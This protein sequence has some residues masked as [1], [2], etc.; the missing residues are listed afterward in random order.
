VLT[1]TGVSATDEADY[2]VTVSNP[3]GSI[4]SDV[5]HLTVL[6]APADGYLAAVL[7]DGPISLWRLEESA[8]PMAYDSLNGRDGNY[9]GGV[10]Y[11]QPGFTSGDLSVNFPNSGWETEPPSTYV[12]VPY[13]ATLNPSGAFS[14]E[15]WTKISSVPNDLFSPLAA[16]DMNAG[17]S[18]YLFYLNGGSGWQFRMGNAAGAYVATVAGGTTTTDWQHIVGV[19]DGAGNASLYVN[20]IQY[21]PVALSGA[22]NPNATQPLRIGAPTGLARPWNGLVDE[23]AFYDHALTPA[24]VMKHTMAGTPLRISIAPATD[25]VANAAPASGPVNGQNFGATWLASDAGRQGVMN[26]DA[27][28][29]DQIVVRGYPQLNSSYGTISFWVRLD[30]FPGTGNESAMV[31]DRR[32]TGGGGSGTIIGIN[33][34]P[35]NAGTVFFQANPTGANPFSTWTT[36]NDGNWH[37]VAVTY[38]QAVGELVT[39]YIDGA[40]DA[41]QNNNLAWWWPSDMSVL[42]GKSRD[43]YWKKLHGRLDDVRFYNRVLDNQEVAQLATDAVVD[44][45]ALVLRLNFD[46]A[47]APGYRLSTSPIAGTIQGAATVD[48]SYTDVGASPCLHISGATQFFRA[49]IP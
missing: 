23:V 1:L 44:A 47:P 21:G 3:A 5:A 10:G 45:N 12:E 36:I 25:I 4:T 38:G 20:G 22:F 15:F 11:G 42:L 46:A 34:G 32:D 49:R 17:R 30:S 37:H 14:I 19:Y 9:V 31:M 13:S 8:G 16:L 33:D 18:G 39:I 43:G 28:E 7:A 48:G 6:S 26:F 29:G 40:M 41:V 24:Q 27:N 35:D 2:T